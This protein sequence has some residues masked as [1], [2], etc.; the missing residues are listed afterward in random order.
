MKQQRHVSRLYLHV[1][2][3]GYSLKI[4][5]EYFLNLMLYAICNVAATDK[6]LSSLICIILYITLLSLHYEQNNK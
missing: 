3:L 1:S 2:T 5:E 4:L 6:T